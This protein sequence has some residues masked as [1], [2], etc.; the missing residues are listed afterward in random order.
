MQQA[1]WVK[2]PDEKMLKEFKTKASVNLS[3]DHADELV[4]LAPTRVNLQMTTERWPDIEF[5]ATRE[6]SGLR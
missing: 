2:V 4:Y 6:Q 5:L 1:R 3:I